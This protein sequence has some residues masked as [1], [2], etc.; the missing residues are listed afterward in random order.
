VMTWH[1]DFRNAS[2]CL[3]YFRNPSTGV[4][5]ILVYTQVHRLFCCFIQ[6]CAQLQLG[7]K[8]HWYHRCQTWDGREHTMQSDVRKIHSGQHT[9]RSNH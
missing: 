9:F 1:S 7:G 2:F 3:Q 5:A 4:S 8:L 6:H